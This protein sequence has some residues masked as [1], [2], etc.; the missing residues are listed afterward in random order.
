MRN[1]LT[2][3]VVKI[4]KL[5]K[6]KSGVLFGLSFLPEQGEHLSAI[7]RSNQDESSF[8]IFY[9]TAILEVKKVSENVH[10]VKTNQTEYKIEQIDVDQL[11]EADFLWLEKV[12][13]GSIKLE[14][15]H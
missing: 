13:N 11:P 3:P 14:F 5:D 4:E 9:T 15:T 1:F 12:K 8:F 7:C 10:L 6:E 2:A